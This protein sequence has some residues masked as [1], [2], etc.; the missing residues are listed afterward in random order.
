L[1]PARNTSKHFETEHAKIISPFVSLEFIP[2]IF[3]VIESLGI[4]LYKGINEERH[5]KQ[6]GRDERRKGGSVRR[7]VGS[8][9]EKAGLP[10][11]DPVFQ[12]WP[13]SAA[14]ARRPGFLFRIT[15]S[16]C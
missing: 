9:D 2:P 7:H 1:P 4:S 14:P 12:D 13:R 16:V 11:I 15:P 3:F 5:T 8:V 6:F 10:P